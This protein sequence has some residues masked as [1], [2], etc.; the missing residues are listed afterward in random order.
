MRLAT[1]KKS[2]VTSEGRSG[3][4][5]AEGCGL[6]RGGIL[7]RRLRC[8][9]IDLK[10]YPRQTTQLSKEKLTRWI[11]MEGEDLRNLEIA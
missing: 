7:V 8:R 4:P 11:L 5:A 3:R 6:L 10:K 9:D 1:R 2:F